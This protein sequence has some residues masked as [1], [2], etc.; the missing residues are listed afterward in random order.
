MGRRLLACTA[1]SVVHLV[2]SLDPVKQRSEK[3]FDVF[4]VH[5]R[6]NHSNKTGWTRTHIC[7][8]DAVPVPG[9]ALMFAADLA[10]ALHLPAQVAI[11]RGVLDSSR[12]Y[13]AAPV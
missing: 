5:G 2:V 1:G 4:L 12:L 8:A 10:Q 7:L 9:S 13:T 11:R 3:K 6:D